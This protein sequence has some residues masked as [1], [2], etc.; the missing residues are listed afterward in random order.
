MI[1]PIF[2]TLEGKSAWLDF[3]S[4]QPAYAMVAEPACLVDLQTRYL[5]VTLFDEFDAPVRYSLG[6]SASI[7]PVWQLIQHCSWSLERI[8]EGLRTL[9]FASSVRD[10]WPADF[11]PER[12]IRKSFPRERLLISPQSTGL[13]QPLASPP[14]SW[15]LHDAIC[16]L[17]N[18]QYR[19]LETLTKPA[20]SIRALLLALMRRPHEWQLETDANALTLRHQQTAT[21]RFRADFT[22]PPPRLDSRRGLL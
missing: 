17:A 11:A 21:I 7:E 18:G 3:C 14:A 20:P 1:I 8:I 19:D 16:L 9:D 4:R 13:L 2:P 12:S 10:N 15:Q 5:Q 22:L 6:S